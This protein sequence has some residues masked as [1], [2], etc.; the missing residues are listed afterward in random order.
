MPSVSAQTGGRMYFPETSYSLNT[1]ETFETP[2]YIDTS[3]VSAAGAG[4]IVK[5]DQNFLEVVSV[6]KGSIFDDYPLTKDKPENGQV[7]VSGI[8]GSAK[9]F[10]SGNGI[11]GTIKW[12]SKKIGDTNLTFEFT[13]GSTT[14]S[15]I[16]VN[17]GNGDLLN[18]VENAVI[19]IS[20]VKPVLGEGT[21]GESKEV[22][23][24]GQLSRNLSPLLAFIFLIS[25]SLTF[26]L[27]YIGFKRIRK[28]S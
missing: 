26:V 8:S 16:A 28:I 13:P 7:V 14:D 18:E 15:N 20:D 24:V 6:E 11:L 12:R 2:I 9:S 17:F 4:A 5:Y 1:G 23:P 27:G 3:D 19:H 22:T 10:F 21:I 25:F